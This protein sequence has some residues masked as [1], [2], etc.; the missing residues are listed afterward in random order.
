MSSDVT[1]ARL[2]QGTPEPRE[3]IQVPGLEICREMVDR[4]LPEYQQR[5]GAAFPT[6]PDWS[7]RSLPGRVEM[8]RRIIGAQL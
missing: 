4:K 2:R 3:G 7:G 1:G 8:T 5:T 6:G